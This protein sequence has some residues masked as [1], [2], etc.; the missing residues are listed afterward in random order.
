MNPKLRGAAARTVKEIAVLADRARRPGAGDVVVLGYHR[1]GPGPVSQMRLDRSVFEAQLDVLAAT[2]AVV[3]MDRAVELLEDP[4]DT[5]D[6]PA[7]VLTFDDGT[8]DF[9]DVVVPALVERGLPGLVY[10]ATGFIGGEWDDGSP[11]IEWGALAE[12]ASAPGISIG[13]HTHRHLLLDRCGAAQAA[14]D[15]DRFDAEIGAHLDVEVRH[16]A[17]PK[18]VAPHRTHPPTATERLLRERYTTAAVAGTRANRPGQTD[19]HRLARSPIQRGDGMRFFH[20]KLAGGMGT[21]DSLR[22]LANTVRYRGA[23]S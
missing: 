9:A 14:A 16:F 23:A 15:L 8:A 5:T 10:V 17:Y 13:G 4:T 1:V 12:A 18:A 7:V 2:G 22:R 19:L 3:T 20:H 21:E 11:G 6:S